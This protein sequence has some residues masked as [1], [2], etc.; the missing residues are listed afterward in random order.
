MPVPLEVNL[1]IF[2]PWH[3][4]FLQKKLFFFF[5]FNWIF[6]LFTFQMLSSFLVSSPETPYTCPSPC[7]YKGAH[8][9]THSLPPPCPGIPL[10]WGMEPS[11]D[12]G[13]PLPLM[14]DKAILCYICSWSHGF[15]HVYSLVG[16]LVP[17]SSGGVC[18]VDIAVLP[19]RLQ[20]PL[21][22]LHS[23]P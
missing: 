6:Y 9:P 17:G 8:P 5:L 12:Q 1:K 11:Q 13:P 16:D 21:Q 10:H 18:L 22:L 3:K 2:R 14:P 23:F 4:P 20:T 15:L 19:M 7:L